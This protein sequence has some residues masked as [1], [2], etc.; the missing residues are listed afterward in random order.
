MAEMRT[1]G[2]F[3]AES[4]VSSPA[5]KAFCLLLSQAYSTVWPSVYQ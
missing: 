4:G 2:C 5:S 3:M 1:L